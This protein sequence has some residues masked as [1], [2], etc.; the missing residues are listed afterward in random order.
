MKRVAIVIFGL[1]ACAKQADHKSSQ[2]LASN[3]PALPVMPAAQ[4]PMAGKAAAEMKLIPIPKDK[5]QLARLVA[6]G[7]TIHQNHMHPPGVR[8][9]PFDKN[10]GSLID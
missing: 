5:A 10:T 1:A 2:Q 9:C 8:S 7:Y 3:P 6:M 4:S